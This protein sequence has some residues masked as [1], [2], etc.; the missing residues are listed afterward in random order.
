MFRCVSDRA[1]GNGN[2]F[3]SQTHL[4]HKELSFDH[5]R[6]T[7][8]LAIWLIDVSRNEI[9]VVDLGELTI[10]KYSDSKHFFSCFLYLIIGNPKKKVV[11]SCGDE[12]K[13]H[14]KNRKH[15][16]IVNNVYD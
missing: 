9:K 16:H 11:D 14:H 6:V 5:Q 1:L 7:G 12:T 13:H 15:C 2:V 4:I 3:S 10:P 8:D